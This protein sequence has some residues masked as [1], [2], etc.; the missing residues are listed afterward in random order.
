MTSWSD[1]GFGTDPEITE[2]PDSHAIVRTEY[3]PGVVAWVC[4]CG[5]WEAVASGPSSARWCEADYGRHRADEEA[6]TR[7]E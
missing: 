4:S 3:G 5:R 1:T 2:L 6:A 7:G